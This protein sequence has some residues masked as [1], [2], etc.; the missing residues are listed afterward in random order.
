MCSE[1]DL[2]VNIEMIMGLYTVC[3]MHIALV[4]LSS[5][6]P[7]VSERKD[8][9]P[10]QSAGTAILIAWNSSETEIHS[11]RTVAVML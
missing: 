9:W 8:S 7:L 11:N 4:P 6:V 5:L 3:S 2:Q 1:L 10:I